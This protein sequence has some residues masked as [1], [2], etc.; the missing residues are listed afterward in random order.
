MKKKH[1]V[2]CCLLILCFLACSIGPQLVEGQGY[3]P[4]YASAEWESYYLQLYAER[5]DE[6]AVLTYISSCF[7][8][9][10]MW[11]NDEFTSSETTSNEVYTALNSA[12]TNSEIYAV[13]WF[14][15]GNGYW[16]Q[17]AT[18]L[19][20]ENF[21]YYAANSKSSPIEDEGV[22]TANQPYGKEIFTFIWTCVNGDKWL[23]NGKYIYG[24]KDSS[25]AHGMPYAFMG[26]TGL[27]LNGY[28]SPD[29]SGICYI[30]FN[31]TA[32]N[33][34]DPYEGVSNCWYYYF[35]E[36]FYYYFVTEGQSVN[37]ALN[38]GSEMLNASQP[39]FSEN[40]LYLGYIEKINQTQFQGMP[41]TSP[42]MMTVYG[43][44]NMYLQLV[45]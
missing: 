18:T 4:H 33:L 11:I 43:D 12:N 29:S 1:F 30:G 28:A 35:T 24:Y 6:N 21:Y 19:L 5:T 42:G 15:T 23:Q 27:S 45:G 10:P 7:T 17:N 9:C 2:T 37:N 31:G 26:T 39:Y 14:H 38:Y 20:P 3:L 41:P 8:Y 13:A 44:G 36:A 16:T 34:S 32:K 22:Y 25:G 40:P